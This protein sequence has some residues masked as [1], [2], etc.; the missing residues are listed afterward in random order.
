MV[1]RPFVTTGS[2]GWLRMAEEEKELVETAKASERQNAELFEESVVELK[3]M[4]ARAKSTFTKVRR[5]LLVMIQDKEVDVEA[6]REMCDNLDESEQETMDIIIRLSEK[7]KGE[8]DSKN[9]HKLSQELEQIEIEYTSAQ[10]RAQEVLDSKL[11]KLS[12]NPAY[13]PD[14]SGSGSRIV[15][16]LE[17]NQLQSASVGQLT[18][19]STNSGLL[20]AGHSV[21][22]TDQSNVFSESDLIGQDL[23]KQLKRVTIPVFSG[24]KRTYQ[25]WK[26]AFMACIDKAPAT[27]EYKLLQLRQCLS[28][29]ALK[30]IESLGHS[31]AAYEAAKD[32]LERKFGGQRRQIA[33]YLEEIDSFRPVRYGNS[34]DLEKYADLLD[35]AVVNLKEANRLE[36]LKDGLLYMK[37]QKKLPASMLTYYHRWIFENHKTESVEVLREWVIREAEF[38]TKALETVQGLTGKVETRSN[39]RGMSHTFFG[40]SSSGGRIESQIGN[41]ICKVCSKQHG[42]WACKEFKELEIPKR[43]DC[44]KRLKLCFRCLGEGHVGQYCY[45]TRV[46]GL[47]GC[48]EVHHRLLHQVENKSS[49]DSVNEHKQGKSQGDKCHQEKNVNQLP[50]TTRKNIVTPTEG[51]SEQKEKREDTT[52]MSETVESCGNIALRTIPVYLKS[53]NRRLKVNALLDDAST[54][55]YVN[56][57]VAAELGLQGHPQRVNVSVLNGQ[58]ETFETTPIECV[59]ESLDGKSYRIT[60]FTTNR[61]TGN[62]NVIDWNTHAKEWSHLKGL[63]FHQLGT[64][65]IVD[66]LIGLDCVDLHYSFKDIR[67]KPGQPIARLTPLGW[68]CVGALNDVHQ[69]NPKTH[70]VRTYFVSDKITVEDVNSVL[71]QFWEIDSS[72]VESLPVLTIEEKMAMEEAERSIKFSNGQYQVSIPWKHNKLSLP[73]NYK[74]ALQRLQNLEKRLVKIPEVATAYSEII[75]KYLEKGYVRK[76]GLCEE[77]PTIKWYLPHFAVVRTDRVTT[78]TRVVFDASAKSGGISLNDIIYQGPKLQRELFDVLLRFRRYRVALV[79]DIAEMY[80]RIQLC[81]ED[82]SCHRFL[83]RDLDT[84]RRPIEYEFSRLVFGINASP[85]LAQFVSQHHARLFEQNYPRAAETILKSTYMDD[86]MDSVMSETEAIDL[87]KQLS[88]LWNKAGM[89]AHKWLSNSEVVLQVIPSQDRACQLELTEDNSLAV[90]TLGVM[91]LAKEDVFTF[92]SKSIEKEFKPTKRNFLK[93]IATLFDPLGFLSPFIIRA[94][95]FL[96]EMWIAGTEWDDLLPDELVKKIELW[97]SEL[98]QLQNI[99]I[100]RSLQQRNEV[101]KINLHTFVDASQGAYGA[102]VYIRIEYEDQT[103][104]VG[105]VAAKTK[106]APLQSISIPRLELM[107]ACLGNKLAQSIIKVLL[108]PIQCVI[109]WSDST[110]VLWWIRG[111]SRTFKPFVAN[112]IGEIQSVTNPDQ[113]RYVPTEL[114][115]ADYLTRGLKVLDLIERE[116]WWKGPKYLQDIEERW[117]KS[118]IPDNFEEAVKEVKRKYIKADQ[119]C[120]TDVQ[121]MID[122]Q[123]TTMMTVEKSNSKLVWRLSPECFSSWKRFTRIYS[124]VVRFV[125]NCR[126]NKEHRAREELTLDEIKDAEKQIIQNAQR[127]AFYDEYVAIQKGRQLPKNSKLLGLC[128]KLDEDGLMRSDSR[129][130]Y[131]EFLPYDVRYPIILP[132]KNWITTLIVKHYHEMGNHNAGTNQTLSALSTK[133]WII[134]AREEIVEWEKKC[135]ACIRRKAKNAVQIMAPLPLN[136]LKSSLRAF[137]R[138]AVD[139]GGPFVT[140]QGRG[141]QRQKRYLCLFTCLAS[142]AVHLEVAYGLDTDSFL[143][144]FYRMCNRRGVP[145]EM[146][147]D[148]GTNFVGANQ[149]LRE[150]TDKM[151]Q[152]SKL[153]ENLISQGI[154]WSFN[155]PLAPHFGGVFETMIKAAK[156]AILAILGNAD[157]TDEELM[158]A[159]TGAESLINSRPLTYQSANPEDDVPLTPNHFLHG[160]IG[161]Q[162]APEAIEEVSYNPKKRWRRIQELTRHFWHRW[163]REWVP[164]LS[165]RKKWYQSRKNLQVGDV[166]LL[167]SSENPRAHWPLG[168]VVEVYPAKD[169]YVRS[170]KLQVGEKQFVRPIVKLCPLEL[171]FSA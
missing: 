23:W 106:V 15:K 35:I 108:I 4:K 155:P 71:R 97:L 65:P 168:R 165:S 37:L 118:K 12:K 162:F 104:S 67:G 39:T 90:K 50:S 3:Q 132:R 161:G 144:A 128:P 83:W 18:V 5:R 43:W 100:P 27:A 33:L 111:H 82:R 110:N 28:G 120:Q 42:V 34:K 73:D 10:N 46:C 107:G 78:K 130:Q 69:V 150:L 113:W 126:V 44:A 129:L 163:M 20:S 103:V 151:F 156:R 171:D 123:S 154:K 121:N 19:N 48:Q 76:I 77:Q 140:V 41:R 139:F 30:A 22:G 137:T 88:E 60:A 61:V 9:C 112:R 157:V 136:R 16:M 119:L 87:Y 122:I 117:P 62:M 36:E 21:L 84:G 160:Q 105:L 125:N 92:K 79:C 99:R 40:R 98:D 80:L 146:I 143:R 167:V 141:K 17:Q 101:V 96:Q 115:P 59:L 52:M 2:R 127:E 166:V 63:K 53:G 68:T 56:A 94:K 116:S 133:Y 57:D 135:A 64:R 102:A 148:N 49:D 38:Q 91:W 6:I 72:G 1:F 134:A 149:E 159:F 131:A 26:A 138:T 89:H 29:E 153:K 25:N 124:W 81:P 85:F 31:A 51:E 170:V 147:S 95:M 142:R 32:R 93:K 14:D 158:T 47:N 169:G 55:T 66:L 75:E 54:K 8:K 145:E 7:Y 74:M 164:S 45:R 11:L 109:F 70:F 24:D 13:Q 114:N 58:V 86:S 152:N